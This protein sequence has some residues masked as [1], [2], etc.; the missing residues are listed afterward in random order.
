VSSELNEKLIELLSKC[1]E[2]YGIS[3]KNYSDCME[4]EIEGTNRWRDEKFR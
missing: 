4:R 3:N 1:E 2:I